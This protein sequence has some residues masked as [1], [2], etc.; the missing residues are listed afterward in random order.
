M[1]TVVGSTGTGPGE[2]D[3][4]NY[5]GGGTYNTLSQDMSRN[6]FGNYGFNNGMFNYSPYGNPYMMK[7][8]A[9][10]MQV[11]PSPPGG[12]SWPGFGQGGMPGRFNQPPHMGY[13]GAYGGGMH[14]MTRGYPYAGYQ[15]HGGAMGYRG[16]F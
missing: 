10:P 3:N 9:P 7:P 8:M 2:P 4:M 16:Y 13:G 15:P 6:V 5:G 1:G 14:G 12:G 11:P